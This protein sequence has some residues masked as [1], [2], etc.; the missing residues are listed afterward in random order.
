[1][2]ASNWAQCPRCSEREAA[3]IEARDKEVKASYGV[4]SAEEF[5]EARRLLA[6]QRE[7][8]EHREE[9]FR[10]DYEIYGAKEGTVVL[11]YAGSCEKCKLRL[12]FEDKR[13][14]PG[15]RR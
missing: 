15:W 12:S 13:E 11:S 1:M 3:H 10:E 5:D 7:K 8:F 6:A 9:T 4:V 2:S 14:I